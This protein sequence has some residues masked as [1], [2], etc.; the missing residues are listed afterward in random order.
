[1]HKRSLLKRTVPLSAARE[2]GSMTA[3]SLTPNVREHG[4]QMHHYLLKTGGPA[5][6]LAV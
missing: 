5:Y 2:A 6:G 4:F 3:L 1:M